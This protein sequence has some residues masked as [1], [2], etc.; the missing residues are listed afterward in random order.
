MSKS[1]KIS[2][3]KPGD[4]VE[5][6]WKD[7]CTKAGGWIAAED[8]EKLTLSTILTRGTLVAIRED[9]I[10][11][12]LDAGVLDDGSL[13]DYHGVGVVEINSIKEIFKLRRGR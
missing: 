13:G 2:S 9:A 11:M 12:A 7:A 5:I 8:A 10:L 6:V 4:A 3:L 1:S